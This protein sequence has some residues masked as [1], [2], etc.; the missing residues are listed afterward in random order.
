ME[1]YTR[2]ALMMSPTLRKELFEQLEMSFQQFGKLIGRSGNAVGRSMY[3][4]SQGRVRGEVVDK[5][6]ALWAAKNGQPE[7]PAEEEVIKPAVMDELRAELREAINAGIQ[8]GLAS[9]REERE[10]AEQP[11]EPTFPLGQKEAAYLEAGMRGLLL[12]GLRNRELG[13]ELFGLLKPLMQKHLPRS[14]S[15]TIESLLSQADDFEKKISEWW[16][17]EYDR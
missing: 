2:E 12:K 17:E 5:L 3:Q 11:F 6:L 8:S 15:A 14:G 10:A 13:N 7:E 1:K 4:N 9:I 16:R